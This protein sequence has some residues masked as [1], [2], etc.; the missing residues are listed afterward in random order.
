MST[1][2][3]GDVNQNGIVDT[4]ELN[5]SERLAAQGVDD[6]RYGVVAYGEQYITTGLDRFAHS[7]VVDT[8]QSNQPMNRL[9]SNGV[10]KQ[11]HIA[12]L[13][14][15]IDH[16]I[17][18][19]RG[20]N[21]DGWDAI[22]HA[23]SEYK[24]RAGAVPVFVLVQNDEGRIE[25]N[26]KLTRDGVLAALRSKNVILDSLV[27]D[28]LAS[29]FDLSKYESN[30]GDFAN[31]RVL[32][33]EPSVSGNGQHEYHAFD[34]ATNTIATALP[35][36]Q[37]DTLQISY[38]GSNTG[39]TGMVGTGKSILIGLNMSGGL[40]PT[41]AGYRAKSVP[42]SVVDMSSG[43]TT[44]TA[45]ATVSFPVTTG[46]KFFG[47]MYGGTSQSQI[48]VNQD[49]TITFGAADANGDNVD[50][51]H[52]VTGQSTPMLAA[53][54]DDVDGG[55]IQRKSVD[56]DN[57]GSLDLVI[58]WN[59]THYVGDN[60][61]FNPITFQAVLFAGGRIQL[62]YI[63]IDTYA[64][65]SDGDA[66]ITTTGG[67]SA[68][69][70]IWSGSTD[71]ITLPAG[72]FVPGPHS[73]FG[74]LSGETN[75][76]YVRLAW[77]TGGAAWDIGVVQSFGIQSDASNALRDTFIASL[78]AQINH[79]KAAGFVAK[80]DDVLY[81]FNLGDGALSSEGFAADPFST[82]FSTITT[83][84]TSNTTSNSIPTT[85][86]GTKFQTI[87]NS[88][89]T[90]TQTPTQFT[91]INL[92]FPQSTFTSLT[93]GSY[94]VELFF[95]EMAFG[96]PGERN[97]DVIVEGQRLLNNYNILDDHAEIVEVPG[98]PVTELDAINGH[99]HVGIVKR[100]E[101]EIGK[102]GTPGLQITLDS[103][104]NQ[105]ALING[106]R[107]LRADAP[108]V[109][110]VVVKGTTWAL[111][112][113][114]S[115]A[116]VVAAGNQLRP[117]YLQNANRI[118][119]HFD[120]PVTVPTN[121]ASA[122]SILGD[123]NSPISPTPVWVNYDSVN[124]IATWSLPNP[125]ATGKYALVVSGFQGAGL[126]L[127][128]E[129]TNYDHDGSTPV[130]HSQDDFSN[131]KKVQ[132]LSGDGTPAGKPFRFH[133]S[134]LP[135]DYDQNGIRDVAD[136]NAI[137]D[138]DGDGII[139]SGPTG[140]DRLLATTNP[141]TQL[142]V[143]KNLGDYADDDIINTADYNYWR[144]RFGTN[145]LS[146]DGNGDGIVNAADYVLW[147]NA[148]GNLSAWYEVPMGSAAGIPVVDFGNA[149]R[150]ANV[151]VSG[152]NSTHAAYSFDTCDGSGEQ[153]RTVPVGGADTISI[154][155]SEDVNVVAEN[156]RLV[157]LR[158]F[159]AP[160]VADFVYD[161]ET[162]TATWRFNAILTNDQFVILLNDDVTDIEGNRLDGEWVN[163]MSLSTNNAA[164][165]E[166]PSGNGVGGGNFT[167]VFTNMAG[168]ANRNNVVD[169]SDYGIVSS[170]YWNHTINALF[171]QGDF[172]GDGFVENPDFDIWT[173][174]YMRYNTF[175]SVAMPA[176]LNGDYIVDITD[177]DTIKSHLYMA[178]PSH[179]NGDINGD[180][181]INAT[182]IDIA[183]AQFGIGLSLVN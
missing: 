80:A 28:D 106:I 153:L 17:E 46:F 41:A 48:F 85:G 114:Y 161:I 12:D 53:F 105:P 4:G 23:I 16:L 42:F 91:D 108:R 52:D 110:N 22:D 179:A 134:V 75:D 131:D 181:Q 175:T 38:N 140:D 109:E 103:D 180:G 151:K 65:T 27:V 19:E 126:G 50:F 25:V 141:G 36:T 127:D 100:F 51:S 150:V 88:A 170:N 86:S 166:F 113:D 37:S 31:L 83:T 29:L 139:E 133:I 124:Y 130:T 81:A 120:G 14:S 71:S 145:D 26:N 15:A 64:G 87:F 62:N 55:T 157:G 173:A 72:T 66:T 107:I 40:G 137:K 96:T 99:L 61:G 154:T 182:D 18:V 171:T 116:E 92:S 101:V 9:F 121:P 2:V 152:S 122:L 138:G 68:T 44:I 159:S 94:I 155:F 136:T 165:S 172:T 82:L 132:L 67:I 174:E 147:R 70:A 144:A 1:V 45:G 148:V 90:P 8:D 98:S 111:G 163:P 164:V 178:N 149:P 57:D 43:T 142:F 47:T 162:M 6:V 158:T 176:D 97:F 168:D 112:V 74:A 115:Y 102:D 60:A 69:V 118:E 3:T 135:G 21:E 54:W 56:V 95:S 59:G 7:L 117:V 169:G 128:G 78:G 20:G 125:L 11:D 143:R 32:G 119:V 63:D 34:T 177:L 35:V 39:A 49:G 76:S 58:Q 33:V 123:S 104:G 84:T 30:S 77:D 183:F 93:D 13:K 146:A 79:A 167:F 73:I 160:A 5:L 89:R 156:L 129:W 10:T 24:F